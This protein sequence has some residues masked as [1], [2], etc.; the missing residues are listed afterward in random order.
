MSAEDVRQDIHVSLPSLRGER[1][2]KSWEMSMASFGRSMS[3]ASFMTSCVVVS[4][5]TSPRLCISCM[6]WRASSMLSVAVARPMM[7]S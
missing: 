7:K 2:S 5:G 6:Y 4:R 3:A 1:D